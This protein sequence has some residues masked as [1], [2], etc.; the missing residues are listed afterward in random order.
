[1]ALRLQTELTHCWSGGAPTPFKPQKEKKG[2]LHF[3][4]LTKTNQPKKTKTNKQT[5]KQTKKPQ[6]TEQ[7]EQKGHQHF[8]VKC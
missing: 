8:G 2:F 5:N 4:K 6:P 3:N 1:M 7:P